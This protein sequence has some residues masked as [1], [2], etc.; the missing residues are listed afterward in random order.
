[1][2]SRPQ[3]SHYFL[4]RRLAGDN[5]PAKGLFPFFKLNFPKH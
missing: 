1:M 2:H 4:K 5:S 3:D